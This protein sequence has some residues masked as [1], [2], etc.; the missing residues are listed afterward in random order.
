MSKKKKWTFFVL[1]VI[2]III[3]IGVLIYRE[4]LQYKAGTIAMDEK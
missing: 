1:I 4:S 2:F 3:V